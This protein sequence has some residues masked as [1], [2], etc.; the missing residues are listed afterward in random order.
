MRSKE[1]NV[2]ESIQRKDT[3]RVKFYMRGKGK[4]AKIEE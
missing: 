4:T 1:R 2:S 3:E